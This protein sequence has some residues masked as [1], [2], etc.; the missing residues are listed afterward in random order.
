MRLAEVETGPSAS[1]TTPQLLRPELLQAELCLRNWRAG[2]R[3]WPAHTAR[4]KKVKE[5]LQRIPQPERQRWPVVVSG[6]EIIWMRGF[7]P[8]SRLLLPAAE[9]KG[10]AGVLIEELAWE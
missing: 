8:P 7:P 4:P 10:V 3:Y 2:D 1:L 5:L 9:A 6:D